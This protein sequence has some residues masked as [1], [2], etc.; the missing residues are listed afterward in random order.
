MPGF[1]E[2][3][4]LTPKA[5]PTE[6]LM[7]RARDL[8]DAVLP[9]CIHFSRGEYAGYDLLKAQGILA[10][11]LQAERKRAYL[12][13]AEIAEKGSKHNWSGVALRDAIRRKAE[14]QG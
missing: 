13:C 1:G 7:E 6:E 3:D 14:E 11:A 8:A 12:E 9:E 2:L 10:A 5:Q 4:R